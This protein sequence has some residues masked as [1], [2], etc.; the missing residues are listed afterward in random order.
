[1]SDP[2]SSSLVEENLQAIGGVGI[3]IMRSLVAAERHVVV[4]SGNGTSFK[5]RPALIC[6]SVE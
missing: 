3:S 2:I 4:P 1:M 6:P 5:L